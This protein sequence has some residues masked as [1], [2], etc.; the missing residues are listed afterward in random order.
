MKT[1][2]MP[3]TIIFIQYTLDDPAFIYGCGLGNIL[4][5]MSIF[6][7]KENG[8]KRVLDFGLNAGPKFKN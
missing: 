7:F 5:F 8:V 4:T 2:V 3:S 1:P 6:I